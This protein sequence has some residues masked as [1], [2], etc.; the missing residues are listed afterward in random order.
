MSKSSYY[1]QWY[2][3]SCCGTEQQHYV[4]SDKIETVVHICAECTGTLTV[5][6]AFDK[7]VPE[8]PMLKTPTANRVRQASRKLRNTNHFKKEVYPTLKRGSTEQRHHAKKHG[9]K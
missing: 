7:E 3:C 4:W 5:K 9:L 2:R 6:H 1:P 8:T